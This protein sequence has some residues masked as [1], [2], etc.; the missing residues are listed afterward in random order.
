MG[1]PGCRRLTRSGPSAA[2]SLEYVQEKQWTAR[3]EPAWALNIAA[4]HV[5]PSST[6]FVL[7]RSRSREDMRNGPEVS[8][9]VCWASPEILTRFISRF[10]LRPPSTD[11]RAERLAQAEHHLLPRY[12]Q[13]W[14]EY[15]ST[16]NGSISSQS[17]ATDY[18]LATDDE[19]HDRRERRDEDGVPRERYPATRKSAR[20]RGEK[21]PCECIQSRILSATM[22]SHPTKTSEPPCPRGPP[23]G[24]RVEGDPPSW[25]HH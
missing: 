22:A 20:L 19:H 17:G 15:G 1:V 11:S 23:C 18:A 25:N 9:H 3:L 6:T 12:M 24:R 4:P 21:A 7:L 5:F 13:S 16:K 14:E 2:C 10:P 8:S